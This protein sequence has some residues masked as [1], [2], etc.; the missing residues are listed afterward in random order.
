MNDKETR[1]SLPETLTEIKNKIRLIIEKNIEY[2][3][4]LTRGKSRAGTLYAHHFDNWIYDT[5]RLNDDDDAGGLMEIRQEQDLLHEYLLFLTTHPE[6]LTK[7]L[8]PLKG[9]QKIRLN[10]KDHLAY[11]KSNAAK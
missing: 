2:N 3:L 6:Q 7:D 1:S 11:L 5:D 8:T 9:G 10:L 4:K